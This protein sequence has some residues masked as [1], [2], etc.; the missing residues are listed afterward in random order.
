MKL[1]LIFICFV[2]FISNTVFSQTKYSLSGYVRDTTNGEA[3]SNCNIYTED[4]KSGVQSNNYG[5]YSISLNQGINK[6]YFSFIGYNT[7]ELIIDI[8]KNETRNIELSRSETEIT[9]VTVSKK[10]R[11]NQVDK[12]E[13]STNNLNI[14][15]I[16]KIPALLGEVDI[17]KSVQLLPGVSTV[18]EGATG[19]NVRGGGIDQNL[20]LLDEAPVFNS[21]HLFGF[22]SVFNPDAV[23]DV[24]LIKGGMPAQYGG[25]ASSTLDVR[26]K[27]WNNKI[28]A[29]NGGVELI[30]SRLS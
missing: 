17:V 7:Y 11:E 3:L 16:K 24:K 10:R 23:K 14:T 2:L 1:R 15:Q 28:F 29:V 19:F 9:G 12:I 18:G 26:M 21:S 8:K 25:R 4:R 30:I 13:M 27:E 20:I 5:F 22:F 6:I